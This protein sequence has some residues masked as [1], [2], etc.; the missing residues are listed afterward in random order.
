MR[1]G[2]K[3]VSLL[4]AL[5][6]LY[7]GVTFVQVVL[8]SRR[9]ET[10]KVDAVVVFGA[11][12][13][14]GRPSPVLKAR[15]DHAADLYHRGFADTV[16][17][18]GGRQPG[19]QFTEATASARYLATRGVPDSSIVRETQGH[20]S[21]QSLAAAARILQQRGDETVLLV[22]DPFHNLRIGA[23]GDELGLRASVSP[24]KSSPIRGWSV[25]SY[26][27]KETV[28]VAA[29]R[30]VGYR[31]LMRVEDQVVR[32]REGARSR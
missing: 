29:G 18:T 31:R 17:V 6:V 26:L 32:V 5:V 30:I 9:D 10:R 12:Q 3:I 20:N 2:V 13:Y 16:V 11:A 25:L 24:T 4:V 28:A 22:S 19:D 23:M 27:G 1:W 8:A 21:W 14:N 7:V 15:L